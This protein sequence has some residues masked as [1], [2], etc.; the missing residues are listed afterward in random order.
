MKRVSNSTKRK[1]RRELQ[2]GAEQ[3]QQRMEILKAL[4]LK[5]LNQAIRS[6]RRQQIEQQRRDEHIQK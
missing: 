5:P 3:M 4:K 2:H 1:S 6:A